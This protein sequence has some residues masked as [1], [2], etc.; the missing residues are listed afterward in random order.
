M[1]SKV[2]ISVF[3]ALAMLFS[4]GMAE[5]ASADSIMFPWIVKSPTVLTLLS[6]VNTSDVSSTC[7]NPRL[8][9]QYWFK[10]ATSATVNTDSCSPQSFLR[11]TSM[12]DIVSFDASGTISG[13]AAL[14]NDQP[15]INGIV[16][17]IPNEFDMTSA[18]AAARAFLLVDNNDTSCFEDA[19]SSSLYGEALVIQLTQGAAWGYIAFNGFGG[20]PDGPAGE[21]TLSF[22]DETDMTGEVIRSPRYF[23]STYSGGHVEVAPTV[24][25][26]LSTFKTKMFV[27]PVNYARYEHDWNDD[28][29]YSSSAPGA[30]TGSANSRIQFCLHPATSK[31][32]Q[33]TSPCNGPFGSIL[34]YVGDDCQ[35]DGDAICQQGGIFDNDES[36]MDSSLQVDVVCTSALDIS[37]TSL[38]KN[39]NLLTQAQIDYLTSRP[40]GQA[41]TY[42]RSMVGSFFTAGQLGQRDV[43]TESDSIIGKLEYT[44][45]PAGFTVGST[46]IGGAVNDF[47]WLRNSMSL[48]SF[49]YEHGINEVG[50]NNWWY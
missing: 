8:H 29:N 24:L 25:L 43:R 23:D 6:V 12:N 33:I 50:I 9:Y 13:G 49:D 21:P 41:W 32:F 27:T 11:R 38:L 22:N 7:N 1:R 48:G 39:T 47:K 20:G 30:R 46:H 37:S 28:T 14:F 35:K 18:P 5:K 4:F 10:D 42:V 3:V 17:Y 2:L 19:Y 44:D 15:P 31:N 26:P 45:D 34:Q 36:P 16:T 40:G